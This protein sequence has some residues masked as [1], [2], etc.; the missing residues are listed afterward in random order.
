MRRHA[1]NDPGHAPLSRVQWPGL[2]D[3]DERQGHARHMITRGVSLHTLVGAILIA[4]AATAGSARAD[5]ATPSGVRDSGQVERGDGRP[6]WARWIRVGAE[7]YLG[8]G[9]SDKVAKTLPPPDTVP[10]KAGRG[11][12]AFQIRLRTYVGPIGF[13]LFYDQTDT[14]IFVRPDRLRNIYSAKSKNLQLL[15]SLYIELL[16]HHLHLEPL[17]GYGVLSDRAKTVKVRDQGPELVLYDKRIRGTG[18]VSGLESIV[19]LGD[20][21]QIRSI[22]TYGDYE[23]E[24]KRL[25]IELMASSDAA[26]SELV[27]QDVKD[28]AALF[29][30]VG[31]LGAWKGD[32]RIDRIF[33]LG[34][35]IR[36]RLDGFF[37]GGDSAP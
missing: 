25:K 34:A 16:G 5:D 24:D 36:L 28:A 27:S 6:Q 15:T 37:G 14:P 19:R 7:V 10:Y 11:G 32:G 3:P 21:F 35:G 4:V 2:I 1:H 17:Y 30:V 33:Y 23:T 26:P 31:Y 13:L 20:G 12:M 29:F 9:I 8:G 22:Y 18:R